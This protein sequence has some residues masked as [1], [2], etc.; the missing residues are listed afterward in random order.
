MRTDPL[1]YI[2][3]NIGPLTEEEKAY[4]QER[5]DKEGCFSTG[6]TVTPEMF[7]Q[8]EVMDILSMG[9]EAWEKIDRTPLSS[10]SAPPYDPVLLDYKSTLGHSDDSGMVRTGI[11]PEELD[12]AIEAFIDAE[13]DP[14]FGLDTPIDIDIVED[15]YK[16]NKYVEIPD[17]GLK[18]AG[19]RCACDPV[20]AGDMFPTDDEFKG[21][22]ITV[23]LP[24][25]KEEWRKVL[26]ELAGLPPE[27][28]IGDICRECPSE[29]SPEILGPIVPDGKLPGSFEDVKCDER[30][31]LDNL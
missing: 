31:T 1:D 25:T 4:W 28:P 2:N 27:D 16:S 13:V 14:N 5:M 3:A 30:A 12:S 23:K 18:E 6:P 20:G 17:F 21:Y 22:G 10:I 26:R 9:R 24:E 29:L 8:L 15:R 7:V 19:R 11:F